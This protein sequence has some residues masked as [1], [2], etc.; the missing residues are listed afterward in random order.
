MSRGSSGRAEETW[1]ARTGLRLCAG[2][3]G[4]PDEGDAGCGVTVGNR[5][6]RFGGV[7]V[8]PGTGASVVVG[9]VGTGEDVGAGPPAC[10]T[11]VVTDASAG[12]SEV[13]LTVIAKVIGTPGVAFPLTLSVTFSP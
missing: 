2:E 9:T 8:A 1:V 5:P 12:D 10:P 13:P 4:D 3:L 11:D 7:I 6:A